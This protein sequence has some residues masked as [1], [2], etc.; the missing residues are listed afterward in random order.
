MIKLK[1]KIKEIKQELE[2]I[3]NKENTLSINK[4]ENRSHAIQLPSLRKLVDSRLLRAMCCHGNCDET[5]LLSR[6]N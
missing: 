5:V 3:T 4:K 6:W 1:I 2:K